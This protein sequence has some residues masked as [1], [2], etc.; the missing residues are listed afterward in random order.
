MPVEIYLKNANDPEEVSDE[1]KEDEVISTTVDEDGKAVETAE[2]AE[3]DKAD[4]KPKPLNNTSP[5]WAKHPNDCT[6]E[7]YKEFTAK[8]HDNRV[9]FWIHLN[10]DYPFNLKGILYFPKI[11]MEY[12]SIE[13]V[14]KLYNNQVF[15]ADNIKEVI[16]EYL[17]LLKGAI[18]CPDFPLNVSRS[19]LQNDGFVRKISDYISKKVADKLSGM[20]KVDREDYEKYRT[21]SPFIKFG[22]LKDDKFNDKMILL[23]KNLVKYITLDEYIEA[24]KSKDKVMKHSKQIW[25]ENFFSDEAHQ[26]KASSR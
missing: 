23:Y 12:E 13:G 7:E 21:M 22:C 24:T 20:Y 10:M 4:N 17:M 25:I 16:P 26:I 8:T 14:I 19:A 1:K 6:D 18:D 2:T 11:N 5:L 3:T 9:S 15:V